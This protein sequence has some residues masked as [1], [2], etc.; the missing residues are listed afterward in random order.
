MKNNAVFT[1]AE[2]IAIFG[3]NSFSR[4]IDDHEIKGVS[5]DTRTIESNNIF[6]ALKGEKFDAHSKIHD[7]FS[8][9]AS[10]AVVEKV[11]YNQ[12]GGSFEDKQ[13]ITVDDTLIALGK[14][15]A[16][17]RARF[18]YP[19]VA[20]G[21]SNGKTTTKDM[22][23]SVLSQK[24]KTLKTFRNFNNRV[25]LPLMILQMS[26]EYEA[27]VFEIGTN[28]PGEIAILTAMLNP[29]HG[30]ITNI[31]KEHLEK[32]LDLDGVELEET[33]LFGI[34]LKKDGLAFINVDDERLKKYT[35]IIEK[36]ITYGTDN[37]AQVSGSV[38]IGPDTR[39]T[40]HINYEQRTIST[41]LNS[42]GFANGFNAIASAAIG[43]KL[44]LSNEQIKS[45]L[46]QYTP[47]EGLGY[48]RMLFE[49]H[50]GLTII[51][52]CYNSNPASMRLALDTLSDYKTDGA[53]IAVLGDMLELGDGSK[54]EH[55][56]I[57]NLAISK[58]D[59]VFL[60][61]GEM[62]RARA[63]IARPDLISYFDDKMEL[64]E[65]LNKLLKEG[66]IVLVKGSRGMKLEE[67]IRA[68]KQS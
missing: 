50:K 52:D 1:N 24:F 61:G 41:R 5:T 7:A 8:R 35:Q 43:F 32:L 15:A 22:T 2:L 44:G 42:Y 38:E 68:I 36:R 25:G 19:V 33:F 60:Y 56:E 65:R 14:L 4:I 40:V 34:M 67:L 21:G 64:A 27:A 53:K 37:N 6:V 63:L 31:Q 49:K 39:P 48:G 17:H 45:G 9:G 62:D 46:E 11:W 57:I 20:I 30:L 59:A 26:D 18:S 23:A 12:Y 16:F 28:E 54:E 66:D 55:M 13:L 58:A 29:T 51:N 3:E 10:A 47:E